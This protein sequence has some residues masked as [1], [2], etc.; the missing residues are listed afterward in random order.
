MIHSRSIDIQTNFRYEKHKEIILKR[1]KKR[2]DDFFDE[3]LITEE[4]VS[5][6]ITNN[7]EKIKIED[8][9]R[10]KLKVNFYLDKNEYNGK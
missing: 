4:D 1:I 6:L 2:L 5:F 7:N 9:N 8:N 3:S 10:F